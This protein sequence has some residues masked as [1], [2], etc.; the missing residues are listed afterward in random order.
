R[1]KRRPFQFAVQVSC[2]QHVIV[3]SHGTDELPDMPR[4][5][6]L[7]LAG[8]DQKHIGYRLP[9]VLQGVEN[10]IDAFLGMKSSEKEQPSLSLGL[11]KPRNK[12]RSQVVCRS[13]ACP[14][15]ERDKL[16]WRQRQACQ[17]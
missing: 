8:D 9:H 6:R 2:E 4:I 13:T 7:A 1:G 12:E 15:P 17:R 14:R 11:R 3:Q 16:S 5:L 10:A